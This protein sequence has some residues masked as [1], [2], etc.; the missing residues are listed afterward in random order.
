MEVPRRVSD[1]VGWEEL[2]AVWDRVDTMEG[3]GLDTVDEAV[4]VIQYLTSISAELTVLIVVASGMVLRASV[5]VLPSLPP[6]PSWPIRIKLLHPHQLGRLLAN[7]N[8]ASRTGMICLLKSSKAEGLT[9][10]INM[11]LL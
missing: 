5:L 6:P 10:V 8:G 3:V 11:V 2:V 4:P 7:V 1:G 9:W